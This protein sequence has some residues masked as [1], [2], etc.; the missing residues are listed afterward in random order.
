MSIRVL[1]LQSVAD[2]EEFQDMKTGESRLGADRHYSAA[3]QIYEGQACAADH[4][5][6]VA[7]LAA[8]F[9]S[10]AGK[11]AT[12]VSGVRLSSLHRLSPTF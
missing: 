12:I 11:G 3:A 8:G 2:H 5:T 9:E 4:G 10:G 6:H 7:S 1:M